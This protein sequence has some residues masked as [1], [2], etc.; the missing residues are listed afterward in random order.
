MDH[1]IDADRHYVE[2][3]VRPTMPSL[4]TCDPHK[5]SICFQ[6]CRVAP[7]SFVTVGF[8]WILLIDK[9][10]REVRFFRLQQGYLFVFKYLVIAAESV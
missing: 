10:M 4:F 1:G 6:R 9:I 3:F 5:Y 8:A 2:L 7:K